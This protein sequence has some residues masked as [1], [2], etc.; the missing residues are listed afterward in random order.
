M[1]SIADDPGGRRRILFKLADGSRKALRL[2][3][4]SRR[5]AD[6]VKTHVENLLAS[7]QFG[8]LPE[9]TL[10]WLHKLDD[11]FRAKLAAVGLI[12]SPE[13][14]LL[15]PFLADY[16]GKHEKLVTG[17]KLVR[18]TVRIEQATVN[19]LLRHFGAAM[20]L[21]AITE[22]HAMDFRD[23][24][25]TT[26]SAPQ[27]RCG[28]KLVDR[29]PSPLCE[30]TTRR[31]CSI[32]GKFFRYAVRRGLIRTN[33][34]DAVPKANLAT[35]RRAYI[36]E[37]DARKVLAE[38]PTPEWQLLFAFSR[39]G[40]LR[41]GSEVRRLT[42]EDVDWA[43]QRILIHSP[44]TA[45]HVGH[46]TRLLPIFPELAPLL[47]KRSA[48]ATEDETLI[49]PMLAG[50][51]DA[52]LRKT[53]ERAIRNAEVAAWPRLWHSLR[54]SRQTDLEDRFPSH[55]V[56]A[57]LGNSKA[58]AQKHYLQVTDAHFSAASNPATDAAQKAAQ[59]AH[60]RRDPDSRQSQD[61]RQTSEK[62]AVDKPRHAVSK[63]TAVGEG[64]EPPVT[65]PPRR[66]SRPV[67]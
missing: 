47:N 10:V 22:A 55:V 42:W 66:F 4:V 46:A 28:P 65:F 30:A 34:F 24:L 25:L 63:R 51:S 11:A 23:Y 35:T 53:L 5:V 49:L 31:R 60:E 26:G 45:R 6:G 29:K 16:I 59:S 1:A 14:S 12:E 62:F 61:H 56:C 2:G 13:H 64:F 18:D 8:L 15:G 27:K 7:R 36:S 40:G 67:P 32:A 17:D 54:S 33:P 9:E 38:L 58:I 19:S 41:V 21:R 3:K 48:E 43:G 44:K 52:S 50:R 39:W 37:A 20:P 57:W